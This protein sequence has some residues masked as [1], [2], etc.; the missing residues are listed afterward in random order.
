MLTSCGVGSFSVGPLPETLG[1]HIPSLGS[2]TAESPGSSSSAPADEP[3]ARALRGS[4]VEE[5]AEPIEP[6]KS[7]ECW[8]SSMLDSRLLMNEFLSSSGEA[9]PRE[10]KS[11]A[12]SIF[13]ILLPASG[14]E[15][16]EGIG[17]PP[18]P[19]PKTASGIPS[20]KES[21]EAVRNL[22]SS[23]GDDVSGRRGLCGTAGNLPTC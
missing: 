2:E 3:A 5:A 9:A 14:E 8:A 18:P 21:I 22:D 16:S 1:A 6:F 13:S 10:T 17:L 23:V 15:D 20:S 19:L 11:S 12:A 4:S 7:A